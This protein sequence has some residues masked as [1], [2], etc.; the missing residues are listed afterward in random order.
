MEH[1]TE[2]LNFPRII[3]AGLKGGSGKTIVSLALCRLFTQNSLTVKPFKK[4]PDYIDAK[5]LSLAANNSATNLDPFLFPVSKVK[6]LF[7]SFAPHSDLAIIEGNRGLFDGKDI[8]G[9]YSTAELSRILKTP[10]VLVIDCTKVTRTV[11]AIVMG[12]KMFEQDLDLAGVILNQ[13]AGERHRAVTRQSIEKY[14]DVPVLGCLP[15]IR[16]NPIPERH[17]GLISDQEFRGGADIFQ[18]ICRI[19]SENIDTDKILSIARRALPLTQPVSPVFSHDKCSAA[20]SVVLGVVRDKA[21]WFY[22]E[23]NLEALRQSGAMIVDLTLLD[24]KD[25]PEIHGLYLGGGF[26]ET[27][28]QALDENLILRERVKV[29]AAKGLPIYA[30]CGGFMYLAE[31]L[32]YEDRCF[33]MAGIL[34]VRTK[35]FKKPQGHG[36]V[37]ARVTCRNPFYSVGELITGHEFHYSRCLELPD[38]LRFCFELDRGV[39]IADGLDGICYRNVLAGYTHIHA[40]GAGKWAENFVK[41]ALIYKNS[42]LSNQESCPDIHC[43]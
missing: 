37:Q 8:Q 18:S 10:V 32:E 6:S 30:E 35:L 11:A 9:S 43:Q 42:V 15:K 24:K 31:S 21:L 38:N 20:D 5:W 29:L 28:A 17:M 13:T 19:V 26:P 36:Y 1:N 14:T 34:P 39:G 33:S 4:G 7:W 22:Y 25:W 40:F 23:E 41:A 3:L 16:Q 12:C 27:M 2:K